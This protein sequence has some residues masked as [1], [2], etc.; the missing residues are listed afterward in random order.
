[1]TM[2]S[3]RHPIGDEFLLDYAAGTAPEPIVL[4]VASHVALNQHSSTTLRGLDAVGGAL[5]NEIEPAAIADTALGRALAHLGPQETSVHAVPRTGET[6]LPPAL[7]A[8]VPDG[9]DALPWKKRTGGLAQAEL[10]CGDGRRYKVSLLRIKAGK[11]I[12][13]HS[14]RGEELL[15]VLSGGFSDERGHYVRG[16]VCF[17][18]DTVEH[19]PLA[20][21]DG[22]CLC[23]AITEGPVRLKG[24]LGLFLGPFLRR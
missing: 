13:R 7:R 24:L 23:L 4:L 16:D 8:Y 15:L 5:L 10:P 9:I 22:E 14:H 18:D 2:L 21:A 19:R 11:A 3:T 6:L 20:H 1:M 12:P 17:A